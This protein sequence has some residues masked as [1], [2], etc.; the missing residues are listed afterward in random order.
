MGRDGG[1]GGGGGGGEYVFLCDFNRILLTRVSVFQ[2]VFRPVQKVLFIVY[3][4]D[5]LLKSQP[6]ADM[7]Q[8]SFAKD[9]N[10]S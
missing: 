6:I 8:T 4:T 2:T 7:V 10:L 1:G 9:K 5:K 3:F